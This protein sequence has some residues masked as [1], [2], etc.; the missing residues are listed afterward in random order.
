MDEDCELAPIFWAMFHP[1]L[2]ERYPN[3]TAIKR[4]NSIIVSRDETVV[5]VVECVE[6]FLMVSREVPRYKT[7]PKKIRAAD[8][9]FIDQIFDVMTS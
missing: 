6:D 9:N 4:G 2:V 5:L 7:E 3:L 8:P 1:Q